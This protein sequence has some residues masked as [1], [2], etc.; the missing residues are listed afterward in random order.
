MSRICLNIFV[1]MLSEMKYIIVSGFPIKFT[2]CHWLVGGRGHK[3]RLAAVQQSAQLKD[4]HTAVHS[5][6]GKRE[7]VYG[8]RQ[9]LRSVV[10]VGGT[11]E[12]HGVSHRVSIMEPTDT[13]LL[14]TSDAA[15]E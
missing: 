15:D 12:P 11:P 5:D 10:A 9:G 3:S 8:A 4:V 7:G 2:I 1:S 13:C 6:S 14:Y